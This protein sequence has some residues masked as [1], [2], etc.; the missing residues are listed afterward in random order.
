MQITY[1][2]RAFGATLRTSSL[3]ASARSQ[4][5]YHLH[6]ATFGHDDLQSSEHGI[7]HMKDTT[8]ALSSFTSFSIHSEGWT[9]CSVQKRLLTVQ[10]AHVI[11]GYCMPGCKENIC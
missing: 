4:I 5:R 7:R 3:Q 11:A 1:A 8:V 10:E 2:I 9:G 6:P